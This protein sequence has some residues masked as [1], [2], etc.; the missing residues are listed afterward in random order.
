VVLSYLGGARGAERAVGALGPLAELVGLDLLLG[1]D[2]VSEVTVHVSI[3]E[4]LWREVTIISGTSLI[5][6]GVDARRDENGI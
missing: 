5:R 4:S 1:G 2:E 6:R 3:G